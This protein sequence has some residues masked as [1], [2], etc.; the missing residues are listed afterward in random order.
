M[1]T[2]TLWDCVFTHCA[3]FLFSPLCS[4]VH[5]L[6]LYVYPSVCL[7][8][9]Q[10]VWLIVQAAFS[11]NGR[12]ENWALTVSLFI[13]FSSHCKL[14][15]WIFSTELFFYCFTVFLSNKC[16]LCE[17]KRCSKTLKNVTQTFEHVGYYYFRYTYNVSKSKHFDLLFLI[18]KDSVIPHYDTF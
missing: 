17:H 9:H 8:T 7:S 2:M 15:C 3:G 13:P 11:F 12:R 10:C 14:H 4:A 6:I 5:L 1:K 16:S 18:I